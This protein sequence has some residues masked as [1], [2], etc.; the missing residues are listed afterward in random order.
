[1]FTFFPRQIT[2]RSLPSPQER[3]KALRA[4]PLLS[5]QLITDRH[6]VTS[7]TAKPSPASAQPWHSRGASPAR[8]LPAQP[9]REK[10]AGP[11]ALEERPSP[12]EHTFPTETSGNACRS[13]QP[14]RGSGGITASTAPAPLLWPREAAGGK[15]NKRQ[16]KTEKG[17]VV[18]VAVRLRAR[19]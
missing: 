13:A 6:A 18:R 4:Q 7:N 12:P 5:A 10:P 9:S 19:M 14:R 1:M 3:T 11:G 2:Q 17:E 8:Q 16:N 15:R